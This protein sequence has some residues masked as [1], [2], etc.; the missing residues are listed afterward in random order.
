MWPS[1]RWKRQ[2]SPSVGRGVAGRDLEPAR[3]LEQRGE[4]GDERRAVPRMGVAWP[5]PRPAR[6]RRTWRAGTPAPDGAR[7]SPRGEDTP[8]VVEVKVRQ[9]DH[10][11]VVGA[12]RRPP[13]G[14]R[15]G[16]DA[17]RPRR[18][19]RAAWA[20]RTRRS[21]PRTGPADRRRGPAGRGRPAGS[22]SR[23]SGCD[24]PLPHR[25]RGVAEHR[26]AVEALRVAEDRGQRAGSCRHHSASRRG[27]VRSGQSVRPPDGA[28][29]ATCLYREMIS[30]SQD[31]G[32]SGRSARGPG[33]PMRSLRYRSLL[34]LIP[35]ALLVA[36]GSSS[37]HGGGA[38]AGT[39]PAPCRSPRGR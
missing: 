24:P 8:G 4:L 10:V 13:P 16:R 19:A 15:A 27:G 28:E 36:C 32:G 29:F 2:P 11:D 39:A 25:P 33:G 1:L 23:S 7:L 18:S 26:A 5:A 6:R 17:P 34:A 30:R 31:P 37:N 3:G 38:D 20:G 14:T 9:D 21:R 22:G 12:R 35:A